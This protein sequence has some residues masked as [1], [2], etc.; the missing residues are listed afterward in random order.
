VSPQ[1]QK[2]PRWPVGCGG[3]PCPPR[4]RRSRFRGLPL[5]PGPAGIIPPRATPALRVDPHGRA[6]VT[7]AGRY[8][9]SAP[10]PC[11]RS[12]GVNSRSPGPLLA[13]LRV[14]LAA[15]RRFA[16]STGPAQKPP[17]GPPV[18]TRF[19]AGA[20][21]SIRPSDRGEWTEQSDAVGVAASFKRSFP[22][23]LPSQCPGPQDLGRS[24]YRSAVPRQH[25][26]AAGSNRP[27]RERLSRALSMRVTPL[28]RGS[29]P[30]RRRRG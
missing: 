12:P 26:R 27:G 1:T 23:E 10:S 25:I 6:T 29:A 7:F 11:G 3:Q 4:L 5:P 9:A 18:L 15:V 30:R 17:G 22:H 21:A 28:N 13:P 8:P 19:A 24:D 14:R 16:V 20:M 2:A